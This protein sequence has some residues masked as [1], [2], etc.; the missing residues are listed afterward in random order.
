MQA[1]YGFKPPAGA[2]L[3]ISHENETIF[4]QE[5]R[6]NS[7]EGSTIS[8][9]GGLH[10][11]VSDY[12]GKRDQSSSFSPYSS[13]LFNTG[14]TSQTFAAFGDLTAPISDALK[15]SGGLRIAYDRQSLNLNYSGKG[16]PGT[17]PA[18]RQNQTISDTYLTGRLAVSYDVSERLM[19]YASLA[20]GYASGGFERYT[21]NGAV[22]KPTN[23]FAPSTAW[24]YETGLK[25]RFLDDRLE[26]A[27]SVFYNDVDDGQLV[28]A[29]ISARP[30]TF[31]FVNQDYD[32]YGFELQGRAKLADGLTVGSGLGVTATQIKN[33]PANATT[34]IRNGNEVPN[35][36][37]VTAFADIEYRFLD[38]FHA[39]L[40]YQYVGKREVDIQNTASLD[41]YHMVNG[42]VGFEHKG[43][44]IYAFGN[45]LLDER[46]VY[47][48]ST[49]SASAHTAVVGPGRVI[50][51][52]LSKSF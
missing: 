24:T 22:G 52:G 31:A 45:N 38:G 39:N 50:G 25:S 28:A 46:P 32:S 13:G 4:S 48:G 23:P 35:A 10:Y 42:R 41:A 19:A 14:L 5:L 43:L 16:F 1:A 15:I 11:F 33:V 36:P 7:L 51:L 20:R 8:W 21:L 3:S 12:T 40:Q 17:V 49:F 27:A 37:R 34:G 6:L 18:Y 47:F 2:D 9:V 26:L 30:V 44:D 29:N